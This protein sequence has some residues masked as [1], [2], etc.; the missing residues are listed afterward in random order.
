M[1]TRALD[2]VFYFHSLPDVC[3][4]VRENLEGKYTLE[5]TKSSLLFSLPFFQ[6]RD[7]GNPKTKTKRQGQQTRTRTTNAIA[8]HCSL[9]CYLCSS[10]R[11]PE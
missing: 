8:A 9:V 7:Q 3:L 10:C 1:A 6:N 4:C 2:C 11:R 5:N